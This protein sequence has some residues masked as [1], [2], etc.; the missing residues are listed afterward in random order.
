MMS[1]QTVS[2]MSEPHT[3]VRVCVVCVCCL[4]RPLAEIAHIA[5]RQQKV[6]EDPLLA[7]GFEWL[8]NEPG[9]EA[10]SEHQ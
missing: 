8:G 5:H 6:V 2:C 10:T 1:S 9:S 4:E 3:I 7:L